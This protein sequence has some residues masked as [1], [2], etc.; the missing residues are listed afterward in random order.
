MTVMGTS[1]DVDKPDAPDV[2]GWVAYAVP[3]WGAGRI[4]G[5]PWGSGQLRHPA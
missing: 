2:A 1:R 5:V 4:W 3:R